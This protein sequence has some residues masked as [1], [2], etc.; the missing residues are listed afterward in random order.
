MDSGYL[1]L[2]VVG[3]LIVLVVGLISPGKSFRCKKCDFR[4]SDP[5]RAAGHVALENRHTADE[6]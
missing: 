1:G 2:L 4:T 3:L 5:L 6:C